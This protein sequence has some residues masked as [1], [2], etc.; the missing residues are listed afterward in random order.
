MLLTPGSFMCFISFHLKN[1]FVI[2][3]GRVFIIASVCVCIFLHIHVNVCI[4]YAMVCPH[5]W[6][7]M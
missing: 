6:L 1:N 3:A 2:K 5:M 4:S 7:C